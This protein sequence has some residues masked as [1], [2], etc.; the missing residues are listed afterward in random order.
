MILWINVN[1]MNLQKT[2]ITNTRVDRTFFN[3]SLIII[4]AFNLYKNKIK[5]ILLNH[6]EIINVIKYLKQ[7]YNNKINKIFKILTIL[8]NLKFILNKIKNNRL[9]YVIKRFN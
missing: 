7:I 8:L 6:K 1:K 5:M 3:L 9:I 4:R 2:I